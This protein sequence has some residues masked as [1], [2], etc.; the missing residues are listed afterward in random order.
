MDVQLKPTL[1]RGMLGLRVCFDLESTNESTSHNPSKKQTSLVLVSGRSEV[2]G[3][4]ATV[5]LQLVRGREI[6]VMSDVCTPRYARSSL[7]YNSYEGIPRIQIPLEHKYQN[8][9]NL[10][11]RCIGFAFSSKGTYSKNNYGVTKKFHAL[12][13]GGISYCN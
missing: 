4:H 1:T 6:G 9:I 7:L 8:S 11:S 5:S 12:K 2:L 13:L 10:L 3:M